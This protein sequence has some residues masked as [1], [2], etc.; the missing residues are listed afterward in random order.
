MG[1]PS[2]SIS[3]LSSSPGESKGRSAMMRAARLGRISSWIWNQCSRLVLLGHGEAIQW[4]K[5]GAEGERHGWAR[6]GGVE[7]EQVDVARAW[8]RRYA[9]C[10]YFCY[11][12]KLMSFRFFWIVELLSTLTWGL[13]PWP[14]QLTLYRHTDIYPTR[15]HNIWFCTVTEHCA[16]TQFSFIPPSGVHHERDNRPTKQTHYRGATAIYHLYRALA[17]ARLQNN[18]EGSRPYVHIRWGGFISISG[19]G[20]LSFCPHP[21]FS[22]MV[23]SFLVSAR[24][25]YLVSSGLCFVLSYF[26]TYFYYSILFLW[27]SF[28][29][30]VVLLFFSSFS[31][32]LYFYF[33]LDYSFIFLFSFK[34]NIAHD[35][36]NCTMYG[37]LYTVTIFITHNELSLLYFDFLKY[38]ITFSGVF[39]LNVQ[40]EILTYHSLEFFFYN[41]TK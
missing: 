34:I 10:L 40:N 21:I 38:T 31:N 1:S 37:F 26:F 16:D 15:Y 30:F 4:G 12:G 22:L 32:L 19:N 9:C 33:S 7:R 13:L 41:K 14:T 25:L 6:A 29:V 2:S 36:L 5:S 17:R 20:R 24:F 18:R 23:L 8:G 3:F 27:P 39:L 28:L 11:S 35:L